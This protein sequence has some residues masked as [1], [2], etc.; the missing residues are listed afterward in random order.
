MELQNETESS[1]LANIVSILHWSQ[2]QLEKKKINF[3]KLKDI[4]KP[5]FS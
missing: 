5:E 3:S 4:S 2:E 1:K